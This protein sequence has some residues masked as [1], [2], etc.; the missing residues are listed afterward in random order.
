MVW[1]CS[2]QKFIIP[3]SPQLPV[4]LYTWQQVWTQINETYLEH[5]K[6]LINN[7]YTKANVNNHHVVQI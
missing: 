5:V 7:I 2:F 1:F 4:Y 6:L 3:E